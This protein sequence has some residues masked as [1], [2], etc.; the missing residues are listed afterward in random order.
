VP[1]SCMGSFQVRAGVVYSPFHKLTSFVVFL[2]LSDSVSYICDEFC[3][4]FA[5]WGVHGISR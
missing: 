3:S 2:V 4:E 1:V 5:E